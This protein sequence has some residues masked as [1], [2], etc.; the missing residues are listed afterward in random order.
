RGLWLGVVDVLPTLRSQ[1]TP[2]QRAFQY[3]R[4]D[5]VASLTALLERV[6]PTVVRTLD[7][8]AVHVPHHPPPT[9]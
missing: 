6:R 1:G 7:P 4:E 8:N 3:T 5:V 2:V 9:G